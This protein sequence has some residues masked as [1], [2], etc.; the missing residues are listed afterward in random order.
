MGGFGD[1]GP[2]ATTGF[3]STGPFSNPA[4]WRIN[5]RRGADADLTLKRSR[6]IPAAADLPV[7]DD[8][9][10]TFG[11]GVPAG[12]TWPQIYDAV[13][14]NDTQ[15]VNLTNQQVLSSFR[16]FLERI[17]HDGVHGWVGDA[18]EFVGQIPGDGG[19]MSFPA[20]SVNDPIFWL[21]HC[22]VDRLW[23]IWQR[24]V[25]GSGY[26]PLGTGTANAGHNGDDTMSRFADQS[27]FNAPLHSRPVDLDDHQA[28]GY[29][30]HSDLP[31]ITPDSLSVAFPPVPELLTTF[32]PATFT[33]R[34]CRRVSFSI[35]NVTGANYSEP[36][37]QGIVEVDEEHGSDV[38][39][40]RVY[41]QFQANGPLGVP[42]PGT[43]TIE[44]TT[45]D[46]DGYD[47]ASPGGTQ[48]L[49]S[50]TI[51][52]TATP[53]ERP[54]AAIGLVLDR[55]GSMSASAGAAGS[56][57]DMLKDSLAVVRDIMRPIDGVGVVTF[58]DV[59]AT[60]N[61]ITEMGAAV[62]PSPPGSGRAALDD[63]IASPDLVPRNL[64]GIGQ[65]MID[66]AAVLD[67]ERLTAGTPYQRFALCVM[68]DGNEN[69]APLVA[70]PAVT[71]AIA[72]YADAIYAIGLGQPGGVSDAVL[73]AI[74][75]YMLIT[76]DITAAERRFRLTKYFLQILAGIT[77][78]AIVVDPQGDLHVGSEHRIPFV[79]S[80]HDVQVDVIALSPL[81]PLLEMTLEAPDGTVIDAGFGAPT[82]EYHEHLDDAF[83]RL[84]LP[85]DPAIPRA[86]RWTAV[87]RLTKE[88]LQKHADD[89]PDWLDR[90]RQ[91]SRTGT[92]P[93]S[94]IVQS[95]GDLELEVGV[96]QSL[97]LAGDEVG[98]FAALT[99]YGQPYLDAARVAAVVTDPKGIDIR[100]QLTATGAG[101]FEGSFVAAQPGLHV[102]RFLATG[103]RGRQGRFQREETRTVTAYRGEISKGEGRPGDDKMPDNRA[104]RTVRSLMVEAEHGH[105]ASEDFGLA[106]QPAIDPTRSRPTAP[107]GHGHDHDHGHGHDHS[108]MVFSLFKRTAD[109]G[110][111]EIPAQ[112]IERDTSGYDDEGHDRG[113][114]PERPAPPEHGEHEHHH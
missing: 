112:D 113:Q 13:P 83:Y 52:L 43:V 39:T 72:P 20:V 93:Y 74:S 61:Q 18:W 11:I 71:A 5:L 76:G 62:L 32:M 85:L 14:W 102:V 68:T 114:G 80:D 4:T 3:V 6:G 100:V 21:H 79:L 75:N 98:L 64:T 53:V 99:A 2:G 54:R 47:T 1:A 29:W 104:A 22:N 19:H 28:L 107:E 69:S 12:A 30:Y 38:V 77:R 42:Q 90:I 59:T 56:R 91:L 110:I 89:R 81:A 34:T 24:K 51:N 111:V 36:A 8:V 87:L 41:V 109:G 33:V 86:G 15:G 73:T 16:K 45:I 50:W 67:T 31:E 106:D 78:A 108:N 105:G 23:S 103:G 49:G 84:T 70:D 40:A 96:K 44:A 57:Y 82:V 37:G 35:T 65:G 26:L 7:R 46:D 92:L 94:L 10:Y 17:L 55:S 88:S 25:P 27:W 97:C 63:V 48:V 60:L 95:Y 9:L 101:R 66:G 58:D